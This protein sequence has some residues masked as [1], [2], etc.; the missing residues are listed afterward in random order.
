[1]MFKK[2]EI[3][4]LLFL[5]VGISFTL[6]TP[7]TYA[8]KIRIRQKTI[9]R[10]TIPAENNKKLAETTPMINF[11]TDQAKKLAETFISSPHNELATAMLQLH[12]AVED[13]KLSDK[14]GA[15]K[16]QNDS[17]VN[18]KIK[19]KKKVTRK[20]FSEE[21]NVESEGNNFSA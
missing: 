8:L 11:S 3:M 20:Y 2:L 21:P 15:F 13:R 19:M 10:V 18:I 4:S 1:M 9:K 17:P 7:K 5:S 14:V 12:H 6:L 16:R